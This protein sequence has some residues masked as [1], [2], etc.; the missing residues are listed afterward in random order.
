MG[1][2]HLRLKIPPHL[3]EIHNQ[4]G[5]NALNLQLLGRLPFKLSLEGADLLLHV[6]VLLAGLV[7]LSESLVTLLLSRAAF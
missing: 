4:P 5:R 3:G 7:T 1:L 6:V 2:G